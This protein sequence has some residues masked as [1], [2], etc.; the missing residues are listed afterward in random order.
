MRRRGH[1]LRRTDAP[2]SLELFGDKVLAR[3][4]AERCGV[5][6]LRGTSGGDQPRRRRVNSSASLGDGASMMI[7][8]VAGG[9]GRGMRAVSRADE[10]DEAYKRCQ[11]GSARVASATATSMS[12]S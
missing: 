4:L 12:S 9:G 7:K 1:H 8:A 10:I 11:S 2:K 6:I 5:P 3:A